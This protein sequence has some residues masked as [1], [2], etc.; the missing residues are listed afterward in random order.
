MVQRT[1]EGFRGIFCTSKEHLKVPDRTIKHL[2][3]MFNPLRGLF[4]TFV[5]YLT[6]SVEY[7]IPPCNV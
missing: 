7:L 3:G 1:F 4:D 5:E 2:R 6:P